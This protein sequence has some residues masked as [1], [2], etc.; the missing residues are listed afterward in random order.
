M[1][2]P[3]FFLCISLVLLILGQ[4]LRLNPTGL[5]RVGDFDSDPGLDR[6][7]ARSDARCAAQAQDRIDPG[8]CLLTSAAR[9]SLALLFFE[10]CW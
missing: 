3:D 9:I 7:A 1:W 4:H 10:E 5:D 2:Q 6:L 8:Q